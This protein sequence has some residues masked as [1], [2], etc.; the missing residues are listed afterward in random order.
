MKTGGTTVSLAL[1]NSAKRYDIPTYISWKLHR[2]EVDGGIPASF[3]CPTDY[4]MSMSLL[5]GARSPWIDKCIPHVRY[6]T[7]LRDP[8]AQ[9]LSPASYDG[10]AQFYDNF[11]NVP[12]QVAERRL[13]I[14]PSLKKYSR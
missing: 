1:D 6:L 13:E 4:Q 5:H 9:I 7:I 8:L 11:Q 3:P 10:N 2:M 12:C 14:D